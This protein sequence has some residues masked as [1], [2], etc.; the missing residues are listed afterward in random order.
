LSEELLTA[1]VRKADE[2]TPASKIDV[3][4]AQVAYLANTQPSLFS[5]RHDQMLTSIAAL[6]KKLPGKG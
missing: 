6:I 2:E 3:L 1:F 4:Q 5:D